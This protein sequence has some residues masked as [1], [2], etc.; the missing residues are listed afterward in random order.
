MVNVN[1]KLNKRHISIIAT[2]SVLVLLILS[3]IIINSL[4]GSGAIGGGNDQS[5]L[6]PPEIIEGEGI[7]NNRGTV[8]PYIP[9]ANIISVAVSNHNDAF[10][11]VRPDGEKEN[12]YKDHFILYYGDE[13][14]NL[15]PYYPEI[16]EKESDTSY[17][18]FYAV[19]GQGGLNLYKMDYLFAAI[20]ALY[21]D[22]RIEPEADI[23]SQLKRY[24]LDEEHRE[25][26]YF[27]YLSDGKVMEKKIFV[28]DTL[29]SG[30]GY[31]FMLEG[32]D[33]IYTSESSNYFKYLLGSFESLIQP[34]LVSKGLDMDGIRE[35]YLTTDYKQWTN[36]YYGI[37]S[38]GEGKLPSKNS[39]VILY[40]DIEQP[41]YSSE[42]FEGDGYDRLGYYTMSMD[43]KS[44]SLRPECER[45]VDTILSTPV[46]DYKDSEI[47]ATVINN[48]NVAVLNETYVYSIFALEAVLTEDGERN[49]DGFPVGS[50]NLVKVKY[51]CEIGDK[52]VSQEPMHAIIDLSAESAIP[53]NVK[54]SLQKS[55]VGDTFN[56][57]N[58]LKFSITYDEN[59]AL[60][61]RFEL[62]VTDILVISKYN[63]FGGLVY[64][65]KITEDSIVTYSYKYLLD[66]KEIGEEGTET[67][68]LSAITEGDDLKIKN[69]LIGMT[70]KSGIE[71]VVLEGTVYCQPFMNFITYKIQSVNGFVEKEMI[72]SFKF[73]NESER[74]P[75]YGE[76]IYA[77][78]LENE[79]RHYA[80]DALSCQMVTFMLGGVGGSNNSQI[81]SG[82]T[83]LETVA[84]GLTPLNMDKYG[85]YD[86]YT[87]Y[88]ELP[89]E[90]FSDANS[91]GNGVGDFIH[92]G[93]LGTYL[94]ISKLQSDGT[95]YIGSSLYDVIAK[96]EGTQFNYLEKSF[97]EYWSRKN[98]V[99]IDYSIIDKL[100][101]D[102]NMT[103]VEGEYEFDLTHNLIYIDENNQHHDVKP[104]GGGTEY[105]FLE[106]K[107]KPL[108]EKIS[109]T[110]LARILAK[111]GAD[112]ID[113]AHVYNRVAGKPVASGHDTAGAANFKRILSLMY[114]TNY[115]GTIPVDE[116]EGVVENSPLILSISFRLENLD[117]D[118]K[119]DFYRVSDRRVM[120]TICRVDNNGNEMDYSEDDLSGFYISNFAAKKIIN[121]FITVFNGQTLDVNDPYWN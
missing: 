24:G 7:Y 52:M 32:R 28:G 88:F 115:L 55:R 59:N 77:N 27:S 91:T 79:N 70:V 104:E 11:M 58:A 62:V 65:D 3:Y 57:E 37:N 20:G 102:I 66:G 112:E 18:D 40:A 117:Y 116:R 43:L 26:I 16:M 75:F 2:A 30:T 31:Y 53:D 107:V 6:K 110:E 106:V 81:S 99:M 96:I 67:V 17:S 64:L 14:G 42:L 9:K 41:K 87:V 15:N 92:L 48:N 85:L 83:G 97:E 120:V 54:E 10:A 89:R 25:T 46:G 111:D 49:D 8:Y 76:S 78:T 60:N 19:E 109:D 50:N 36:K 72:V 94:Y 1:K 12:T 121:S 73:V 80:L 84:V 63:E 95:R 93:T 56:R 100:K 35:P 74:D 23:D 98:L 118:Y 21:F 44:L 38:G 105:N 90:I 33:Y 71:K 45:L 47:S 39:E 108:S 114:G 29:I 101:V 5:Q 69:N 22:N 51:F 82:L 103:G 68:D 86:G 119:Y 13:N 34:N 113:I 4:I 61:R